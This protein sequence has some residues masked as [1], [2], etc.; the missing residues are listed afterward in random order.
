MSLKYEP[1]SE[2]LLIVDLA[3]PSACLSSCAAGQ[4]QCQYVPVILYTGYRGTSLI[5]NS[6]PLQ[7]H[8]GTLGIV[9]L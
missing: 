5:R 8:R 6:P 3:S 7:D 1:S 9:P 2:P 4:L